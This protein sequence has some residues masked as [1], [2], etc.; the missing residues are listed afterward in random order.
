MEAWKK[1]IYIQIIISAG[2]SEYYAW[3]T[4][5]AL[6]LF[7]LTVFGFKCFINKAFV[8]YFLFTCFFYHLLI[9]LPST[10]CRRIY[11]CIRVKVA[12]SVGLITFSHLALGFTQRGKNVFSFLHAMVRWPLSCSGFMCNQFVSYDLQLE[13][14]QRANVWAH[15]PFCVYGTLIFMHGGLGNLSF[16]SFCVISSVQSNWEKSFV[17]E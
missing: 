5:H 12:L 9:F 14:F 2:K 15:V 7:D 17:L 13:L 4:P 10:Y 3:F 6:Q 11:I 8:K 1:M 16:C